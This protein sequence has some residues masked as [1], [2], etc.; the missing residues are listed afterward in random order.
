[1][2]WQ[3]VGATKEFIDGFGFDNE[4]FDNIYYKNA[5]RLLGE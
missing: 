1:M 3:S 2:P 4:T 5:L